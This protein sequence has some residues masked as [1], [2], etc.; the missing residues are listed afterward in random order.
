[1]GLRV[2]KF[3]GSSVADAE[4]IRNVAGRIAAAKESGD[5]VLAVVS[6]RGKTTDGLV[7]LA[8]EISDRPDPREMDMLLSTGERISCALMAMALHDLG[9]G[10]ESFTGSQ[11]GILTD[12]AHTK[13]RIVEIRADRLRES[14][15]GGHIVLVAGFQGMSMEDRNVTTLGRGGSD[16][17]AVALATALG[18][19]VCEIYTDVTGVFTADPRIEPGAVKLPRIT[20]EEM[21]EMAAMGSKVLALRSVEF[22]RNYDVP[23][24]VRSSFLLDEGTWIIKETP[25]MEQAIVSGIAHKSDEAKITI[26]GVRDQPGIAATIFTALADALINVDTIIQNMGVDGRA[27]LSFTVPLDELSRAMDALEAARGT[28]EFDQVSADDQI[29]KVTLVGAGMKSNPGIAAKMFRVLAE[30]DINIQMIDTSTIRIT[31]VI[32]RRD[33]ERAVRALHDAF[34]L[35]SEAARRGNV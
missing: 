23:L 32:N 8:Y 4:K 19:D 1:M 31:V 10:A 26:T 29:G 16:T 7:A 3:G 30:R 35:A 9:H 5:D 33:V 27:D 34:D 25:D 6:A 14:I 22:A 21:L 13:A 28:L 17:T 2:M 11:A 12:S 24:H 15:D 18:A 20:H